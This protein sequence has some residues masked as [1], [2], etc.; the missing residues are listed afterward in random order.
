MS[1]ILDALKKAE[2]VRQRAARVPTLATVHRT[3]A[4]PTP[5]RPL[6]PWIAG[7]LL[8]LNTVVLGWLLLKPSPRPAPPSQSGSA[9]VTSAVPTDSGA[10]PLA[11][12]PEPPRAA[13]APAAVPADV[14]RPP[15]VPPPA[16]DAAPAP[17][18]PAIKP[19]NAN[20]LQA[21]PSP[22]PA[23]PEIPASTPRVRAPEP[24]PPP[25]PAVPGARQVPPA[26]TAPPSGVLAPVPPIPAGV[27]AAPPGQ[28]PT[29]VDKSAPP[30]ASGSARPPERGGAP[31][32]AQDTPPD[33]QELLGRLRLQMVVYSTVPAQRL[34]Y[35]DN[36]KYVEGSSIEGKLV[37]ESITP[38]GAVL[39]HDGKRFTIHQ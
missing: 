21:R 24:P 30:P 8:V 15:E 39:T 27:A 38:D 1:Y 28:R 5:R 13:S 29:A 16:R 10:L 26:A 18:A 32:S 17:V 25:A 37:V 33:V 11:P 9:R 35:I 12:A 3:P 7:G 14:V 20:T 19:P 6:W 36:Q 23:P 34:V 2:Q 22:L 4:A 31:Q